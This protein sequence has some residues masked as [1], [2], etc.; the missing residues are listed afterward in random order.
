MSSTLDLALAWVGLAIL[1]AIAEMSIPHFGVI[2]V[3][4][5]ALVAALIAALGFGLS[6]QSIVFVVALAFCLT[7]LR[8]RLIAKFSGSKFSGQGVPSRTEALIGREG[9]VTDDIETAVG[10]GRVNVGGE[11]WA[12]RAPVSLAIGTHVRVTAADGIVLEVT[13]L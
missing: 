4:L 12:A 9:I 5:A 7:L 3:S 6:V 11:D 1:A 10:N 13:P 8:P 2:F